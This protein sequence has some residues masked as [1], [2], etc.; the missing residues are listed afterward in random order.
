[1][2]IDTSQR[3][4]RRPAGTARHSAGFSLIEL[5]IAVA[6]IGILASIAYPSYT[7][8]VARANT[9]EAEARLM[10]GAAAVERCYTENYSYSS[11]DPDLNA[12]ETYSFAFSSSSAA[13]YS[14]AATAESGANVEEQCLAI[15]ATGEVTT[16]CPED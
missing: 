10:E 9:A 7:Q 2:I 16:D 13:S 3:T 5:M 12:T 15:N 11:C 4:P 14:L 1:M 6:V 8:Y